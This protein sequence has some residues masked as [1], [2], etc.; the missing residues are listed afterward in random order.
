MIFS[1]SVEQLSPKPGNNFK[2]MAVLMSKWSDAQ[3]SKH[4]EEMKMQMC[5]EEKQGLNIFFLKIFTESI[6]NKQLIQ[7]KA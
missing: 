7:L 6:Y 2:D 3:E 4:E 5:Y 1:G